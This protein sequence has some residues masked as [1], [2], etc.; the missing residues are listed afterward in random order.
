MNLNYKEIN[1][2]LTELNLTNSIVRNFKQPN[3]ANLVIELYQP[4]AKQ[5][6]RLFINLKNNQNALFLSDNWPV[7]K[8][9]LRFE[10]CLKANLKG[11]Y[12]HNVYQYNNER[13]VVFLLTKG[14]QNY[15]L[16]IK[17][18]GA[19][20]NILLCNTSDTIIDCFYRRPG[21]GEVGGR[22]FKWP[23]SKAGEAI[24]DFTI[25]AFTAKTLSQE[26]YQEYLTVNGQKLK[27]VV[28]TINYDELYREVVEK[29]QTKQEALVKVVN[30][31]QSY[32][33][34]K[35]KAELL[36]A[37][38]LPI[39]KAEQIALKDYNN[40]TIAIELDNTLSYRQNIDSYYQTYH[41][42]KKAYLFHGSELAK[43]E[44][45]LLKLKDCYQNN[46][47]E[48]VNNLQHK[49]QELKTTKQTKLKIGLSFNV[50]GYSLYVGRNA[51]ENESLLKAGFKGNDTF[52]H[53]R[54]LSGGYVIIKQQKNKQMPNEVL[55]AA[56]ALAMH[57]SKAKAEKE[58]DILCSQ[59]KNVRKVKNGKKGKVTVT[60]D[61]NIYYRYN[62]E[63]LKGLLNQLRAEN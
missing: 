5:T 11:S 28:P 30:R 22:S 14:E 47:E 13:L 50:L 31:L 34:Y 38:P 12:L 24:K 43:I 8:T 63:H 23:Q 61:K 53:V 58:A 59:L 6:K 56:A 36:A 62:E 37:N 27:E 42:K 15:K 57:Y 40:N 20:S 29:L 52:L 54:G 2:L 9:K 48:L 39:T 10:E 60:N 26:L 33:D 17:L 49:E 51:S 41:K 3:Y 25:R 16:I 45:Q 46:P 32:N 18:W 7:V 19:S 4:T 35:L 21:S 55:L 1:H 44:T